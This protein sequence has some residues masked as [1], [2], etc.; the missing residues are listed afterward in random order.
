MVIFYRLFVSCQTS[1]YMTTGLEPLTPNGAY[2]I[3]PSKLAELAASGSPPPAASDDA[4]STT[5]APAGSDNALVE[6]PLPTPDYDIFKNDTWRTRKQ[7]LIRFNKLVGALMLDQRLGVRIEKVAKALRARGMGQPVAAKTS[8]A[9]QAAPELPTEPKP[10]P[11]WYRLT[12]DRVCGMRFPVPTGAGAAAEP[13]KIAPWPQ[14]NDLTLMEFPSHEQWKLNGYVKASPLPVPTHIWIEKNRKL[15]TG[16]LEEDGHRV[17]RGQASGTDRVSILPVAP[18]PPKDKKAKVTVVP[19]NTDGPTIETLLAQPLPLHLLQVA[20]GDPL[21]FIRA[22]PGLLPMVPVLPGEESEAAHVFTSLDN[23]P[24][25]HAERIAT[26]MASFMQQRPGAGSLVLLRRQA[27]L[28]E[29][30]RP[31]LDDAFVPMCESRLPAGNVRQFKLQ[32]QLQ[33]TDVYS[34]SESDDDEEK[35]KYAPQVPTA[36][37]AER[38]FSGNEAA[39]E[40]W[41]PLVLMSEFKKETLPGVKSG[42]KIAPTT[43]APEQAGSTGPAASLEFCPQLSRTPCQV[44]EDRMRTEIAAAHAALYVCIFLVAILCICGMVVSNSKRD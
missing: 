44:A 23:F 24:R 10:L 31:R 28:A 11:S 14:F 42:S 37:R 30:W 2:A 35:L 7:V 16:A 41:S 19:V 9:N 3:P 22:Q 1:A 5:A 18:P 8:S 39:E 38:L 20:P 25:W 17:I 43:K 27:W 36:E 29:T 26:P 13:E 34:D 32:A 15:R 40:E 33:P 4:T 6:S 12:P 21:E